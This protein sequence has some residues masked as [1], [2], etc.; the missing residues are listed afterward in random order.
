MN[1]ILFTSDLHIGHA[2]ILRFCPERPF[3][4][5][6]DIEAHDK[7]MLDLWK[8]TVDPSDTV[9]VAG[10][11][12][13]LRSDCARAL[14]QDLPGKKHLIVGNHDGSLKS[15][16]SYFESVSQ[17]KEIVI[18]ASRVPFLEENLRVCICHYPILEWNNKFEG[19]V[20]LH[21]H[22]H[23]NIDELNKVSPDLRFDIGIDSELARS[24]A[25]PGEYSGLVS[26]EALY[27]A[28]MKKTEGLTPSEYAKRQL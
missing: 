1:K 3:A 24:C 16:Y 15:H 9:Y 28:I 27:E 14:V 18:K 19:A 2:G 11:L 13:L 12:S 22:C 21:A 6:S 7:Y 5:N 8:K 26:L 23:G 25:A 20:M 10:D 4:D 17:I